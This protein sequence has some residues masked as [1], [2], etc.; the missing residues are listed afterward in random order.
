M[1]KQPP[2]KDPTA[3]EDIRKFLFPNGPPPMVTVEEM[4]EGIR[5]YIRKKF[6]DRLKK[7]RPASR[8]N[9]K[10]KRKAKS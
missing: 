9:A 6:G 2:R 5:D 3:F 1:P 10:S 4:D 7:T 8:P